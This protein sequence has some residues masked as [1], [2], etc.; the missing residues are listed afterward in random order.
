MSSGIVEVETLLSARQ[1]AERWNIC[2]KTV[3]RMT[4][5]GVLHVVRLS[6]RCIRYKASDV[7]SAL[8]RMSGK[9]GIPL[10]DERA[11]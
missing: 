10:R 6:A 3:R 5:R 1:V 11:I 7:A 4:D 2:V 8:S 9:D